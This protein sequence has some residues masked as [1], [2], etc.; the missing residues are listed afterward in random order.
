MRGSF[1][2]EYAEKS[3]PLG[4]ARICREKPALGQGKHSVRLYAGRR[5]REFPALP[6]PLKG[7]WKGF[8]ER[9][10]FAPHKQ[11]EK[12]FQRSRK[13]KKVTGVT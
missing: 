6:L 7:C 5:S 13:A 12:F 1:E 10:K 8:D 3:L 9:S 2:Q 11:R 4:R